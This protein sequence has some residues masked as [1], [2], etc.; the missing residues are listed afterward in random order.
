MRFA[1]A[2]IAVLVGVLAISGPAAA[3]GHGHRHKKCKGGKVAVTI[4]G[5][6]KCTQLSKAL[7]RPKEA[8]QYLI[9]VQQAL[10]TDLKGARH[11]GR[12]VPS[13]RGLLGAKGVR[14]LEGAVKKGLKLSEGLKQARSSALAS[15]APTIATASVGCGSAGPAPSA[16]KYQGG[17]FTGSVDIANGS[18]QIGV[19]GGSSGL[20]IELDLN[21]CPGAGLHLPSCPDAEGRLEG[22]DESLMA[23]D[24]KIFRGSDLLLGQRFSFRGKTR[25]EPV[26]VGDDAKLQYFEIDHTYREEASINGVSL[27]L[28]YHGHA[29]VTYP[30]ANYDPTNTDVEASVSVAG[31][32]NPEE[33]RDYE[34][35]ASLQAKPKADKIFADEV[36][37][38]IKALGHAEESW[39]EPNHCARIT[40]TP[41][42]VSRPL[43]KAQKGSFQA[44]ANASGG[45][46]P[47]GGN[48][49]LVSQENAS[50][51]PSS[52]H[53]NPATFN[54]VVTNGGEGVFV[55]VN[56]KVV[57][58][59]GVA[60]R[61][62]VQPTESDLINHIS[63]TFTV[64]TDFSG[65]IIEWSGE[66]TYDRLVPGLSG[67]S[68]VY[69]LSSGSVTGVFKGLWGA[70]PGCEWTGEQTF[71]LHENDAVTV[72]SLEPA[73]L[74]PPYTYNIE[75]ALRGGTPHG[76][77]LMNCS[78]PADNGKEWEASLDMDLYTDQQVSD[79]GIA[80]KGSSSEN[81]AP[82][83][84]VEQTW[85]FKG[86]K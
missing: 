83:W 31:V 1:L 30:G 25:I 41:E 46:S 33:A 70:G 8:D 43:K 77:T 26:Q 20:R 42:N 5:R 68:G 56:L 23:M 19:D 22:S 11:H 72:L 24:L 60:E 44:Q 17:G 38:V 76:I 57:S 52:A 53:A 4:N 27:N 40:Y 75:A 82:G 58:A 32:D 49:S 67:A 48:W 34:F 71:P 6:A 14:K 63:G 66:A 55:T 29:R 64:T 81:P 28:T 18:A 45:G 47:S 36:E 69:T 15:V 84:T 86:T 21:L 65:S 12:K 50:V 74:E 37:K 39:M 85:D 7:P 3:K 54:Y 59:A 35:D 62:W 2:L 78:E 73:G 80:Y 51:N 61:P 10:G 79:D 16:Q 9:S 13:A